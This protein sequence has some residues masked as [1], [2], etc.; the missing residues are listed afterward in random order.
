M[1]GVGEG[2]KEGGRRGEYLL[3]GYYLDDLMEGD[4][5]GR[6]PLL[7]HGRRKGSRETAQPDG[8]WSDPQEAGAWQSPRLYPL[9]R[10]FK[11]AVI[12]RRVRKKQREG[13]VYAWPQRGGLKK[14]VKN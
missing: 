1:R 3:K 2:G 10:R 14:R 5:L 9:G 11:K 8:G 6:E 12:L 13:V 4:Y 7:E